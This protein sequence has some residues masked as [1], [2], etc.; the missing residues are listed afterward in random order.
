[1]WF[2]RDL[3]SVMFIMFVNDVVEILGDCLDG[4]NFF[5]EMNN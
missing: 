2:V 1:M 3:Y 4:V 5:K